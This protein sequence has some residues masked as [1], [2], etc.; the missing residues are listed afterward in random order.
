MGQVLFSLQFWKKK[1]IENTREENFFLEEYVVNLWQ[2]R[3]SI[4]Q[5]AKKRDGRSSKE[6]SAKITKAGLQRSLSNSEVLVAKR[7]RFLY[8]IE[9][10]NTRSSIITK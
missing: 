10:K 1:T 9:K 4:G 8:Y 6:C 7:A 2:S 5:W 3:H